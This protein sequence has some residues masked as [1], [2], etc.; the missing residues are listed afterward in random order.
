VRTT[1]KILLAAVSVI[2]IGAVVF[3][4]SRKQTNT[5][6]PKQFPAEIAFLTSLDPNPDHKTWT[7]SRYPNGEQGWSREYDLLQFDID[8]LPQDVAHEIKEKLTAAKGW[9]V[10]FPE[11][12]SYN[13]SATRTINGKVDWTLEWTSASQTQ[14]YTAVL[15]TDR[16]RPLRSDPSTLP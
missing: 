16:S 8:K 13:G 9:Q 6:S 14:A 11:V 12:G 10:E 2:V 1:H 7:E 3:V 15:V 4:A 5:I